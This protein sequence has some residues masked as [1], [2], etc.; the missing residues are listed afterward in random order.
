MCGIGIEGRGVLNAQDVVFFFFLIFRDIVDF[1][2]SVIKYMVSPD[3]TASNALISVINHKSFF[4]FISRE[5]SP[6]RL[7]YDLYHLNTVPL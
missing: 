6:L 3:I 1:L 4:L 2:H 5:A 7:K